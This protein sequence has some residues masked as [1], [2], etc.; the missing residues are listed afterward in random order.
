MK[1]KFKFVHKTGKV[2]EIGYKYAIYYWYNKLSHTHIVTL[3]SESC[4]LTFYD[5]LP[6]CQKTQRGEM[7]ESF[8]LQIK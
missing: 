1:K 7:H 2:F 5:L 4:T 6:I 8:E 3:A